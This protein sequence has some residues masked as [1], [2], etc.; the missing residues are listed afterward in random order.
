MKKKN[1]QKEQSKHPEL[2]M[3]V[4]TESPNTAL[5]PTPTAP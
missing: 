4:F 3:F 5:E 2:R 1:E